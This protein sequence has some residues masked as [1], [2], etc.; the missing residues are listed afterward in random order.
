MRARALVAA[1]LLAACGREKAPEPF[2][3]RDSAGARIATSLE[4]A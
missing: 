4:P 1:A 2:S 3:V